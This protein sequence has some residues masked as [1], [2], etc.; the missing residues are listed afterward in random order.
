MEKSEKD[1]K[2][3]KLKNEYSKLQ[4]KYSLPSFEELNNYF[5]IDLVAG[6]HF[7]RLLRAVR[8]R[9][10]E[11][12]SSYLRFMEVFLNP[13][14]APLFYMML[15]K[16]MSEEGRKAINEIYF[17]LGRIEILH[18]E[19]E[20]TGSDEREAEFIKEIFGCWPKIREHIGVLV[21]IFKKGWKKKS[22]LKDK[23]YFG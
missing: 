6:K 9:M 18:L 4:E 8:R 2:L 16:N 19:V 14:Q 17:E 20:N 15:A 11:K 10:T 21:D 7:D 23:T 3:E 13:A 5:D 12:T 1:R 22:E